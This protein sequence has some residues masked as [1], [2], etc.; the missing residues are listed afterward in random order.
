MKKITYLLGILCLLY[1]CTVSQ[2][3]EDGMAV[4]NFGHNEKVKAAELFS[5]SFLKLETNE[6][7]LLG[8]VSQIKEADGKLV[9]LD[10]FL[11]HKAYIFDRQGKF[12]SQLGNIGNGPGEY[13]I[14]SSCIIDQKKGIVSI[15][16]PSQQKVIDYSLYDYKFLSEKK[17]PFSKAV[18]VDLRQ[19]N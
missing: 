5:L 2:K 14:P 12:I 13:V 17:V 19:W 3:K 1:S 6:N 15:I 10:V 8:A 11:S 16:D 4:I 18:H 7:A 9:L